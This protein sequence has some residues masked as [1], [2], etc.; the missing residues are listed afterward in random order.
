MVLASRIQQATGVVG[1]QRA[2]TSKQPEWRCTGP[3]GD[4][5]DS[6]RW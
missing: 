2:P 4:A 1:K 6:G 3:G 5:A